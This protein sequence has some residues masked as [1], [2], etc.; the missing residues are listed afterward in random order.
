[1]SVS[2]ARAMTQLFA[3]RYYCEMTNVLS[4]VSMASDCERIVGDGVMEK[5]PDLMNARN[6]VGSCRMAAS[7]DVTLSYR[8]VVTYPMALDMSV[9][10]ANWESSVPR[11]KRYLPTAM[12]CCAPLSTVPMSDPRWGPR[13]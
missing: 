6:V 1:M 3:D 8:Y 13:D 10:C 5:F 11:G 4:A 9:S 12:A 2:I 7:A